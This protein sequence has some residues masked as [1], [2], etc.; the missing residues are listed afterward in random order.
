MSYVYVAC[1]ILLMV[2]AQVVIKW[3]VI[4]AGALPADAAARLG[5]LAQLLINP[6][7]ASALAAS[8]LAAVAWMAAM[9]KLD[10][11]HAYPFMSLAFVLVMV[12]SAYFFDEPLTGPK[13][14][15]VALICIG[16]V[17]GSQG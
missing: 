17:V 13:I 7:I 1:T 14:A 8:L 16:I 2:Y 11:S 4:A 12:A 15:G 5:F 9:T 6:W 10:L 3:Q